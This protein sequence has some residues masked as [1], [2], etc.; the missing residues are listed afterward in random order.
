M[1]STT[2]QGLLSLEARK[3]SV[4]SLSATPP[5]PPGTVHHGTGELGFNFGS[6]VA[7]LELSDSD[8]TRQT[9][10]TEDFVVFTM[11][12]AVSFSLMWAGSD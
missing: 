3:L 5:S 8:R 9:P 11:R 10:R 7:S 1:V 12:T 6:A 4:W 2:A